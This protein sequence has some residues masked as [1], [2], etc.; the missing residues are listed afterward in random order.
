VLKGSVSYLLN[1][2]LPKSNSVFF[3]THLGLRSDCSPRA[4]YEELKKSNA[5][6]ACFWSFANSS[7]EVPKGSKGLL[8]C[9]WKYIYYLARAKVWVQNSEFP[10]YQNPAK[11][12]LYINT[13]HGT[14]YKKMGLDI[15]YRKNPEAIRNHKAVSWDYLLSDNPH[16]T[17]IFKNLCHHKTKILEVGYPRNDILI[18]G[19]GDIKA[20]KS[21]YDLPMDQRPVMLYAPTYREYAS[22]IDFYSLI[23]ELPE[24]LRTKYL[25][26]VRSHHQNN[27]STNRKIENIIDVS[28]SR[29]DI[30]KLCLI[31]DIL[32]TDY[33][34]V[35]F[36]FLYINKPVIFFLFDYELYRQHRGLYFDIQELRVGPIAFDLKELASVIKD[37]DCAETIS[38]KYYTAAKK[39]FCGEN[40]GDASEKIS[41]LILQ[42]INGTPKSNLAVF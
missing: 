22:D 24:S 16:C 31:S 41:K 25:F 30:Q 38:S 10:Y 5:S 6:V 40:K 39:Q 20:I 7:V 28:H 14:P 21:S 33:S 3:E 26:L 15:H 29:F 34:S 4:I 8:R 42:Y 9:S 32:L 23:A 35:M 12:T 18:K 36:D 37:F 27:T 17:K 13:Q 11:K 2:A 19:V 1:R